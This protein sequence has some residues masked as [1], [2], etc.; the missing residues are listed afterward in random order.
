MQT[1]QMEQLA[2]RYRLI[3][4]RDLVGKSKHNPA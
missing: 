2:Q 1:L 3:V 4:E